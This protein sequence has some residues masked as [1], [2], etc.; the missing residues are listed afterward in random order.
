MDI[1]LITDEYSCANYISEYVNKCSRGVSQFQRVI[2]QSMDDH[3]EFDIVDITWLIG[4]NMLNSLEMTSQ[5]AA[6]Y[7][8]REPMSK[9]SAVIVYIPTV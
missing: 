4:V 7:L 1:Q 2:M 6:W 3:P 8:L 9:S 5:E